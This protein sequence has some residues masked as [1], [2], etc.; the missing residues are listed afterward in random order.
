M[1]NSYTNNI[2]EENKDIV[3]GSCGTKILVHTKTSLS[4]DTIVIESVSFDIYDSLHNTTYFVEPYN[5]KKFNDAF[6]WFYGEIISLDKLQMRKT[7]KYNF[8][9]RFVQF[10]TTKNN[11]LVKN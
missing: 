4:G 6:V 3:S 1:V 11:S 9:S 8:F 2:L 5:H 7:I 10:F